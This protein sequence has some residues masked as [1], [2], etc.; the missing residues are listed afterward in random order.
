MEN[1][2][3]DNGPIVPPQQPATSGGAGIL[4]TIVIIIMI[5]LLGLL[6]WWSYN[7]VVKNGGIT[8]DTE[9]STSQVPEVSDEND[10]AEAEAFLSDSEIETQLDTSEIDGALN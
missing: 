10:L 7:N 3:I 6:G 8:A 5:A 1:E 4:R 9:E 2:P